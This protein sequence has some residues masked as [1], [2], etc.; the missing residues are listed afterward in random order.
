MT[1]EDGRAFIKSAPLEAW[2]NPFPP[3]ESRTDQKKRQREER[4]R[5]DQLKLATTSGPSKSADSESASK[6]EQSELPI[7]QLQGNPPQSSSA[8]GPAQ[9]S[10]APQFIS[11]YI[12][13]LPDS[14]LEFLDAYR[15]SYTPLLSEP[16]FSGKEKTP[17]PLI[18]THC[19]TRE[20]ERE[21]ASLDICSVS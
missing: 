21:K 17:M 7:S 15:G 20:L 11:H 5:R 6:K 8:T 19:F 4:H 18:H 3:F 1:E 9:P 10:K 2:R 12:M 16:N 13:N 14:A